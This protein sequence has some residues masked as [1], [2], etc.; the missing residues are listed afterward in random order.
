MTTAELEK[1]ELQ[2]LGQLMANIYEKFRSVQSQK[3]ACFDERSADF[4]TAGN[5]ANS[6]FHIRVNTE[7]SVSL[8]FNTK[9]GND[10]AFLFSKK[11]KNASQ[12][13]MKGDYFTWNNIYF[14]IYDDVKLTN[15]DLP[16]IKQKTVECNVLFKVDG[17]SYYGAFYSSMRKV[18]E[19]NFEKSFLRSSDERPL[20]IT[21][22][23]GNLVTGKT[24]V[25]EGKPWK[26]ADYDNISNKGISYLYLEPFT[27]EVI[28]PIEIPEEDIEEDGLIALQEYVFETYGAYFAAVPKVEV[29]ERKMTS[30]KFLIPLGIN[31]VLISTKD[32]SGAI[33]EKEYEVRA[34]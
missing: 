18:L 25:I 23:N 28:P 16:Y 33:I 7:K 3:D 8:I 22:R 10:E 24:F 31:N 6:V 9:E 13:F 30:V 14:L 4:M 2:Q 15:K 29:I 1:K 12:N 20:I 26:I 19:D 32:E 11:E 17:T 34:V 27:T 5:T 21:A